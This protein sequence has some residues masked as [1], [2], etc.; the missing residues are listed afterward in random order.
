MGDII[1][2]CIIFSIPIFGQLINVCGL[3]KYEIDVTSFD[4]SS[5]KIADPDLEFMIHK[6]WTAEKVMT[7][8]GPYSLDPNAL[9]K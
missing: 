9:F 6:L 8:S 1:E 5:F 4:C 7:S 3:Y 2:V